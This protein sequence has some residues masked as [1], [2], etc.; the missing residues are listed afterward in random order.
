MAISPISLS[1]GAFNGC[2]AF[3]IPPPSPL[4]AELKNQ[5]VFIGVTH[6]DN[7]DRHPVPIRVLTDV[8]GVYIVANAADTLLRFGQL[9]PQSPQSKIIVKTLR[10]VVYCMG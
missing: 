7:G 4:L 10:N 9:Q 1:R 5:I 8:D 2:I 6:Q 3:P